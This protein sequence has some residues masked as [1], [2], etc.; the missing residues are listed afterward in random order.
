MTDKFLR[1]VSKTKK[2]IS[3]TIINIFFILAI[4]SITIIATQKFFFKD[5]IPEIF[6][7]K[8]LQVVS[9]SMAGE[10]EVGET[11][12]IKN[13][14]NESDLKVGDIVTYNEDDNALVTHRIV[15]I[16]YENGQKK[17]VM[18][19]DA[20]NTNDKNKV[21]YEDIEGRY[22]LKMSFLGVIVDFISK[23]IGIAVFCAIPLLF[24]A[25]FNMKDRKK[26]L[27]KNM[28]MEKRLNYELEEAK[29][30]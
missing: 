20:N 23:P 19:G 12:L 25:I 6:G 14:K 29:K 27:K 3:N 5:N 15:D 4:V 10:I 1:K 11:I 24:L 9:G 8:M 26:E 13:V 30:V 7:Y 22:V 17:Y 18:K 16:T 2:I 21:S 28:R